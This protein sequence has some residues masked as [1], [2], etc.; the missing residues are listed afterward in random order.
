MTSI[1]CF[2]VGNIVLQYA[3]DFFLIRGKNFIIKYQGCI[4]SGDSVCLVLEHVEHDRPEVIF[5]F[6]KSHTLLFLIYYSYFS[7]FHYPLH[8]KY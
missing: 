4:K 8:V 7:L 1:L 6:F 5:K 3:I 2:G